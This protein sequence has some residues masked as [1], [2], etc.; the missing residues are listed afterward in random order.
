MDPELR[1]P[2]LVANWKMH[3][4]IGESIKI[5]TTLHNL[6][7]DM[8]HLD[9]AVAPP[10]TAMYSV[11]VA[12]ADSHIKLAGQNLLS[13]EEGAFTGE[14]S[15]LFL[16][17]IGCDYVL[18]GHSERRQHFGETDKVV[19]QKLVAALKS[20]LIPILCIGETLEEREKNQTLEII[21]RQLKRAFF[22]INLHD[23]ENLVVAYEP[24]WAI[25]TGKNATPGQAGEVHHAIRTWLTKH[26]DAPTANRIRLLYGGSVKPENAPALMK[27]KDVDGLLVGS[28][29]LSADSF[30]KIVKF[31]ERDN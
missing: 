28:A 27:E 10:F 24:V 20:D 8:A 3:G 5:V 26:F 16:K 1:K 23:F 25:G 13:D 29:S 14:I 17:D 11:S 22:D 18:V 2:L 6:I 9:V 7:S 31:E 15:G 19:G 30:A 4:T 12:L 21:E